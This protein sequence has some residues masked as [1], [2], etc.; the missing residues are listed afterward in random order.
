MFVLHWLAELLLET[1]AVM[2]EHT[3]GPRTEI[4][5]QRSAVL[6][7][8]ADQIGQFRRVPIITAQEFNL[9]LPPFRPSRGKPKSGRGFAQD[10]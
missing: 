2:W 8:I 10:P 5:E 9:P 3:G 7:V 6:S 4:D 1:L